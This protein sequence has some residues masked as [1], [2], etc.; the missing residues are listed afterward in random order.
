MLSKYCSDQ[1]V[2]IATGK[3]GNDLVEVLFNSSLFADAEEL[4]NHPTCKEKT[5]EKNID[6]IF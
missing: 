5:R 6:D 1:W 3:C 4:C 2:S